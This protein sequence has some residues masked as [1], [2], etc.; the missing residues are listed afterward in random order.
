M[1]DA[2]L[3]HCTAQVERGAS[4]PRMVEVELRREDAAAAAAA[5]TLGG[6][7]TLDFSA[8]ASSRNSSA[9]AKTW[10]DSPLWTVSVVA[11]GG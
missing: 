10:G 5:A 6:T 9:T 8:A 7:S 11:E 4:N 1:L 2:P 3:W